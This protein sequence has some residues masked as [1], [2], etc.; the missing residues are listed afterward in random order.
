MTMLEPSMS[1]PAPEKQPLQINMA[2]AANPF[3][4]AGPPPNKF[5][6]AIELDK[7]L[8]HKDAEKLYNEL[9]NE[10]FDNPIVL[11]AYGMNLASQEKNGLGSHLLRLV[12][13]NIEGMVD[14]FKR[15]GIVVND[16]SEAALT[17]FYDTKRAEV[18]NALGTCYKHENNVPKAREY[19][20]AAQECVPPNADI[21]NNIATLYINEG[22]PEDALTAL[23]RAIE[24][25]PNHPQA[26]WNRS[27]ANLEMGNYQAGWDEYDFGFEAKVRGERNYSLKPLPVWDGTPGKTI[28]V[29]GEQGIGD[30]IMFASCLPDLLKVS[31]Q[32]V[33]DCHK[34]LHTLFSSTWPEMDIYPTREDEKITWPMT[35]ENKPR[36]NFDARIAI[37]SLPRFFRPTLLS[38][39]GSPYIKPPIDHEAALTIQLAKLGPRPKIGISWIGG[40]KRT[41]VEV[42]STTLESLLPILQQD[43]DFISLQYTDQAHEIQE[44]EKAHH[45]KIHQFPEVTSP[46]YADTAALVANLDLVIT[47]C[48]S[49]VHLAG[50]MG[51][52]TWV[53][54]P[55]RPAWR[56]R[57]DL[58]HMP[59]YGQSITLFRQAHN[60]TDWAPV[61]DE[62]AESL[63]SLLESK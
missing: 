61:V 9:L 19:F 40:H 31:K 63:K 33:F 37:G 48:T 28:V 17:K 54:T 7:Q 45:I 16:I 47:V 39:P 22:R 25:T 46:H 10:D 29:Y 34:K 15:L 6:T 42:R 23:N 35:P 20:M 14:G 57:L 24:I 4:K 51:V 50:S 59:W 13:P 55:S 2:L 49:V 12:L 27:L 52:P 62:V 41:R 11:A 8:K 53:L 36:Y 5:Q 1:F 32:V 58:D 43:A 56:Y 38:F 21:Q 30:E 60:S 44:F 26:K 3:I 18:L